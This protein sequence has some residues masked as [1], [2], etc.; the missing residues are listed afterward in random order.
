MVSLPVEQI[1]D[2]ESEVN[3]M[4]GSAAITANAENKTANT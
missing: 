2:G 3:V 1:V 4:V